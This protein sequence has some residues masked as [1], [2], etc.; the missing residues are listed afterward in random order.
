MCLVCFVEDSPKQARVAA[1]A[2]V[3]S[4]VFDEASDRADQGAGVSRGTQ[5]SDGWD[6]V[7]NNSG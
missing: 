6:Q 4:N 7:L 1:A 2:A 5:A 3:A